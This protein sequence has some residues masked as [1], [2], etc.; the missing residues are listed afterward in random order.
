MSIREVAKRLG[1]QNKSQVQGWA[2]KT[3]QASVV[4]PNRLQRQFKA[5]T[6]RT[7]LVTIALVHE[8]CWRTRTWADHLLDKYLNY[9]SMQFH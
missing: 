9:V 4:N 2:A 5:D 8:R 6:P 3:K 7:K 1:I